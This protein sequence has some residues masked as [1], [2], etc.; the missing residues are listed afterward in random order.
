M[1]PCSTS[2]ARCYNDESVFFIW[3]KNV[4]MYV[5]SFGWKKASARMLCLKMLVTYMYMYFVLSVHYTCIWSN[6]VY[7][8]VLLLCN[9]SVHKQLFDLIC[10]EKYHIYQCTA[11]EKNNEDISKL[12]WLKF[13][14]HI[15]ARCLDS[16]H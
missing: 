5:F 16:S 7:I 8:V 4:C 15:M 14:A 11:T 6:V 9:W 12:N 2:D 10:L 13:I 3:M 1:C